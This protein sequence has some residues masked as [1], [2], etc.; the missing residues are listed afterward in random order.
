MRHSLLVQAASR[1]ARAPGLIVLVVGLHL[2]LA[3]AVGFSTRSV[4]GASMEPYALIDNRQLLFA[5]F[6]LLGM[7][8]GMLRPTGHLIV[9][10]A[11]IGWGFWTLLAAGIIHRLRAA[12]P[13]PRLAAAAVRGLPGVL[14]MTAWHLL[15]RA[16]LL[17]VTG[18]AVRPLLKDDSWGP[19]GLLILAS[20]FAL[21]ICALDLARC[22][23]V[24]H[25][26]R[27]FHPKTAWRGLVHALR[28]PAILAHS[29]LLSLAQWGCLAA[30]MLAAFAGLHGG[31]AI[32]LARGLAILGL[33]LGL[34]RLAV[35]VGA[36]PYRARP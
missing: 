4:I 33:L 14:A 21:C 25:G 11:V 27:R 20:V 15:I 19:V 1:V 13:L 18:A 23:V 7:S 16:V 12:N 29:M 9:G 32:W 3:A 28:R 6:E 10:S 22:E 26:A 5:L 17:G 2:T 36:G 30:V 8:P 24:L 31:P 35:A 34:T